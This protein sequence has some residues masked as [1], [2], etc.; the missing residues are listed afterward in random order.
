[1][2][3][4]AIGMEAK[5][6]P[7]AE[8]VHVGFHVELEHSVILDALVEAAPVTEGF[9]VI[10]STD[11][12]PMLCKS[13]THAARVDRHDHIFRN[14]VSAMGD[15]GFGE[16]AILSPCGRGHESEYGKRRRGSP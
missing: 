6:F 3:L 7:E 2:D 11:L 15:V 16:L 1:M 4:V 14:A 8:L 9:A 12:D 10:G 5:S 13:L